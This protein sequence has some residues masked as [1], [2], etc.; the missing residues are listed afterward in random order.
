[1]AGFG[2]IVGE[3]QFEMGRGEEVFGGFAWITGSFGKHRAL[4]LAC[5]DDH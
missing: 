3:Y 5:F 2:V 1:M 4:E